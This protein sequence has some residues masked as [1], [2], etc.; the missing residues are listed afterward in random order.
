MRNNSDSIFKDLDWSLLAIYGLLIL[1]GWLNIYAAIF[2]VDNPTYIIDFSTKSGKQFIWISFSALTIFAILVMDFKFFLAIPYVAYA[3]TAIL[4]LLLIPFGTEINGAKSWIKFGG[5]SIQPSEFAK[6]G[7]CLAV[8]K[9]LD[10]RS[11]QFRY[12]LNPESLLLYGIILLLPALIMIQP[13][14]GSALVYS[15]FIIM[16]CIDGMSFAIPILGIITAVLFILST[17]YFQAEELLISIIVAGSAIS[18]FNKKLNFGINPLG[19]I[20]IVLLLFAAPVSVLYFIEGSSLIVIGLYGVIVIVGLINILF[21]RSFINFNMLVVGLAIVSLV[22]IGS[23]TIFKKL[24]SH[25]QNRLNVLKDPYMDKRG[26]GW[27]II[28]SNIAIS[29]GGIVGK[30]FKQGTITKGNWVPEQH[31]DFIFCTI[32]EEHGFLGTSIVIMLFVALIIRLGVIAER[33][34]SR[35]SQIYGYSVMGIIFF[36]FLI[37]VGMVIGLLPVIGIPLPFFS[38][39]GSSLWSF[40]ILLTIMVKLDLHRSQILARG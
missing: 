30:G 28:Q 35:F 29:S 31:T 21:R 8:A 13:D 1:F 23:S 2:D 20:F 3:A 4:L 33:Q 26:K 10:S 17:L 18:I 37:N 32:G 22:V 19:N 5:F 40:T 7:A 16:M 27:N 38:Y 25:H 15:S 14:A 9:Y 6:V 12:G 24:P 34:K 11:N 39:G 36:H